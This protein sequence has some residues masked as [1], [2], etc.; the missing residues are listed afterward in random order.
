MTSDLAADPQGSASSPTGISRAGRQA[1]R[2]EATRRTTSS[3]QDLYDAGADIVLNGHVHN[4]ER[5]AKQKL[6]RRRRPQTGSGSSWWAPEVVRR[7]TRS[8]RR[9]R[10]EVRN[11]G[12]HGVL[13]L[14]LKTSSY[15]W[16]FVPVAGHTFTDSGSDSC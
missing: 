7:S 13:K 4:Y 15:D 6:R 11:T 14:T 8:E 5:F 12:T 1:P 9:R 3:G 2:T 16:R 10:S